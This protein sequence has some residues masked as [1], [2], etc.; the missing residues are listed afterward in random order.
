MA[1]SFDGS[2]KVV[3]ITTDT[4]LNVKNLWSRYIDW[5]MTGDN[6]KYGEAMTEIGGEDID[7]IAGTTIPVY[8]FLQNGWVVKPKEAN[9]TLAVTEGILLVGGGGDPFTNTTG[10]YIVRINY[11]Q[12]VQAIGVSGGGGGSLTAADVWAY[13][14]RTLSSSDALTLGQFLALK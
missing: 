14:T 12:P 3:T 10:T 8:V 9:H 13:A 7:P 6:S 2:T 1:L 5:Y 4:E 11:Q